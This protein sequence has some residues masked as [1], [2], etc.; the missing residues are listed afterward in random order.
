MLG[1]GEDVRET[2]GQVRKFV[3][4]QPRK[5]GPIG[6]G[7]RCLERATQWDPG[8][9]WCTKFLFGNMLSFG[10]KSAHCVGKFDRIVTKVNF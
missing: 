10:F 4:I 7:P 6:G 9:L 3:G 2:V 8:T 5:T 1:T